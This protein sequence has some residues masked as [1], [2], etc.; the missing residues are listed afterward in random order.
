MTK[1]GNGKKNKRRASHESHFKSPPIIMFF[2]FLI[3]FF[4]NL[5]RTKHVP[6]LSLTRLFAD[7]SYAPFPP[8]ATRPNLETSSV[9][10]K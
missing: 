1:P 8:K 7:R 2:S 5:S 10:N 4:S 6:F 9:K 3:T